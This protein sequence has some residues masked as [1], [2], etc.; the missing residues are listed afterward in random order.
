M[1][2]LAVLFLATLAVGVN[3]ADQTSTKKSSSTTTST[4]S[5]YH[6]QP[7]PAYHPSPTPSPSVSRSVT[8]GSGKSVARSLSDS[9]SPARTQTTSNWAPAHPVESRSQAAQSSYSPPARSVEEAA[10]RQTSSSMRQVSGAGPSPRLGESR[11][12]TS[13]THDASQA[14]SRDVRVNDSSSSKT[15]GDPASR[16]DDD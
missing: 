1:N 16:D 4:T 2:K 5:T 12:T 8:S 6:P 15:M 13:S 10:V 14:G 3:A 11:S 7:A 9:P